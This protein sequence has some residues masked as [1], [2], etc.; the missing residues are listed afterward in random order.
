MAAQS[1]SP[2]WVGRRALVVDLW[3]TLTVPSLGARDPLVAKLG[4]ILGVEP[5]S[6]AELYAATF[7]ERARGELGDLHATLRAVCSMLG[8]KPSDEAIERAARRRLEIT[9]QLMRFRDDAVTTLRRF[10][11]EGWATGLVTDSSCD[12]R[13]VWGGTPVARL[14]DAAVFSCNEGVSKPASRL[15]E[16]AVARLG[17]DA[18]QCVYVA[19]GRSGELSAAAT[20]GMRS[21]RLAVE[22]VY[23][24]AETWTGETV[25]RLGD[26][27]ALLL[28]PN[29]V[30]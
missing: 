9:A 21:V 16:V 26:L 4:E 23:P 20:L 22:V 13:T 12:S 15:F 3:D 24:D 27:P 30:G 17:V 6:F 19:D 28:R 11:A 2:A 25:E 29:A 14:V 10:R 5:W 8:A 18:N 7:P 1:D